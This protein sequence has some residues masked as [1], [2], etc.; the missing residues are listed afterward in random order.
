LTPPEL[1]VI[2]TVQRS[3]RP[4]P[5]R[6]GWWA[7][8]AAGLAGLATA[9]VAVLFGA[10][11]PQSGGL[12]AMLG[13]LSFWSGMWYWAWHVRQSHRPR[14]DLWRRR[15]AEPYRIALGDAGIVV[16][17]PATRHELNW[18]YIARAE[19]FGGFLLF[20]SGDAALPAFIPERTLN[21]PAAAADLLRQARER[22]AAAAAGGAAG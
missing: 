4:T 2:A 13:A 9:A 15:A 21:T 17:F 19:S 10:V 14:M 11:R 5:K 18:S 1:D 6:S 16:T 22:M 7:Y 12:L 3:A 8:V 20:W